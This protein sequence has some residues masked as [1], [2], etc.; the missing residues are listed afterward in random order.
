MVADHVYAA[1]NEAMPAPPA[2][3]PGSVVFFSRHAR[4]DG[5]LTKTNLS[6]EPCMSS[7]VFFNAIRSSLSPLVSIFS[8][9]S[10]RAILVETS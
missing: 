5:C 10:I 4:S 3:K 1:A 6:T 8:F 7:N 2:E 9:D